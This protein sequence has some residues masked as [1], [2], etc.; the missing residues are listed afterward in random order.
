MFHNIPEGLSIVRSQRLHEFFCRIRRRGRRIEGSRLL[1]RIT[2]LYLL[3][4]FGD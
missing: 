1:L 2:L 3:E 4:T